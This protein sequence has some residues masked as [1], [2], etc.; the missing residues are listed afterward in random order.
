MTGASDPARPAATAVR[1]RVSPGRMGDEQFR[2]IQ[3]LRRSS[4][5]RPHQSDPRRRGT[6]S[7]RDA[8]AIRESW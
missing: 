4:A 7:A 5:A 1:T 6:R 8:A 2:A 3:G